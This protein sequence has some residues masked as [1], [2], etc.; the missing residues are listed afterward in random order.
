MSINQT[1]NNAT[2]PKNNEYHV[3]SFVGH[4]FKKQLNQVQ[5]AITATL[6]AEI[7]ATSPEGKIVFTIEGSSHKELGIKIDELK[8]HDGFL[9]ISPVYHQYLT[10]NQEA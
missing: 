6:G 4:A 2:S 5:Q 7:H 10:E 3:A 8:R 1:V 9:S